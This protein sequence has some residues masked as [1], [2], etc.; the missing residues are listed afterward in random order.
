MDNT[1]QDIIP[2]DGRVEDFR[3]HLEANP[4]TILSARF[5]D[6]KSFF[7]NKVI[8]ESKEDTTYIVVHPVHYQV[9]DN[10]DIFELVK[11]DILLQMIGLGMLP[12]DYEIPEHIIFSYYLQHNTTDIAKDL[13]SSLF[14]V[15]PNIATTTPIA[16]SLGGFGGFGF[17]AIIEGIKSLRSNYT[18]FKKGLCK[19]TNGLLETFFKETDKL[20]NSPIE[21]DA[22]TALIRENI[23][24]WQN[25]EG[26]RVVLVFEDMDRLDP[27]HLFRIMNV[28]SA[29]I[30]AN[31]SINEDPSGVTKNRFGVNNVVLVLDYDN[32]K[33]IFHHFYGPHTDFNGYIHKFAPKGY[34]KYS[35]R[36]ERIGYLL[37][38]LSDTT[39]LDTGILRCVDSELT[40]QLNPNDVNRERTSLCFILLN[41]DLRTCLASM[42]NL[43]S[44]IKKVEASHNNVILSE[45]LLK[46]IVF[47]KRLKYNRIGIIA[48]LYP[49]ISS[50]DSKESLFIR[51]IKLFDLAYKHFSDRHNQT[52]SVYI[53]YWGRTYSISGFRNETEETTLRRN[54][55]SYEGTPTI[56]PNDLITYLF[57]YIINA[58]D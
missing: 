30:D 14:R 34:F 25:K 16:N 24:R 33:S 31:C 38:Q 2:I 42:K 26:K 44:D 7:L 9:S 57:E 47:L 10:K 18:S 11:R 43:D 28:L 22:I 45:G 53:S 37:K 20:K 41:N 50:D 12:Q 17:S 21:S 1:E 19:D 56:N 58:P 54:L 51:N 35:L 46:L 39:G 5:G 13:L 23:E 36:K 55:V 27:T 4:R 3:K 6:G 8:E 49:L 52:E 15:L 40:P 48:L 29:Q 32:L